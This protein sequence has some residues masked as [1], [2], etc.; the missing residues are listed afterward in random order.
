[1]G[2]SEDFRSGAGSRRGFK[3]ALL[4]GA[5]AWVGFLGF[6]SNAYAVDASKSDTA[7][8]SAGTAGAATG[9]AAAT[10]N[11]TGTDASQSAGGGSG[12]QLTDQSS[13]VTNSG[14]ANANTGGN[15]A[16]GN[17][18]ENEA[19]NDQDATNGGNADVQNNSGDTSN[20]S[21]GSANITT[22]NA[23]SVGNSSWTTINQGDPGAGLAFVD[24]EAIVTNDGDAESDTGNNTAIGN[25]SD[26]DASNDQEAGDPGDSGTIL[27]NNATTSNSSDGTAGVTTGDASSTGT[28]GTTDVGQ[29]ASTGATGGGLSFVDQ[30]VSV[31]NSGDADADTGENTAIGNDSDNEVSN[32]QDA[33][34]ARGPPGDERVVLSNIGETSNWSDGTA[35]INT[36]DAEATGVSSSTSITQSSE[37]TNSDLL[38][39]D[40]DATIENDGDAEAESG[41]NL[42]IG[43]DSD[44]DATNEQEAE[45]EQ[46]GA[47]GIDIDGTTV[48]SNIADTSNWS[49]GSA[50]IDT[51]DARG[52]GVESNDAIDQ[53]A[54]GASDADGLA[55]V[56]QE[57]SIENDGDGTG[58]SGDNTAIGNDSENEAENDQDAS[59]EEN[60]GGDLELEGVVLS[61]IADTS[62][63]SNGSADITT[64]DA[65]G[66]GV[67]TTDSVTQSA[68]IAFGDDGFVE[69]DQVVDIDNDGDASGNSG[70][71]LAIGNDSDNDATNDQDVAVEENGLGDL[72]VDDVV[73]SN[74]GTTT[75]ESNGS[76]S[77][78]TGNACACNSMNNAVSQ[79]ANFANGDAGFALFTQEADVDNHGDSD[80]N[81]G[82][83]DAI[84]NDS[85]NDASNEQES[86]VEEQDA[87]DLSPDGLV[88]S[89][90]A[91]NSNQSNGSA[92]ISTGD[93]SATGTISNT[94]IDQA[95]AFANG[96]SGFATF[97]QLAEVEND[98]D[99]VANTGDNDATGNDS[100]NE[101]DNDQDTQLL[102]RGGTAKNPPI[103]SPE[104]DSAVLSNIAENTNSSNGSASI[105]TGDATAYG[106]YSTT[107]ISQD[108][109]FANGDDG[110][111][112]VTQEADV[113]NDGDAD[114]NTG[115]NEA[116]GNNS[117]NDA[118]NDQENNI[119]EQD[120]GD[121]SIDDVV[122]S[123]IAD[124][125]NES[126]GSADI[127]TGNATAYGNATNDHIWQTAD[128][129]IE[130]KGFV[131]LDQD[132]DV[133]NS[134]DAS[135]NTGDNDADGNDSDNEVDNDQDN[136]IE[137]NGLGDLDVDDAVL[138]NISD[139]SNSSNGS[140]SIDSG[141]ANALGNYSA[142]NIVLAAAT[143]SS[144]LT[145]ADQEIEI[146]NDGDADANSGDN[147]ATGNESDNDNENEQESPL[148]ENGA[149]SLDVDG[150][151]QNNSADTSNAS[152]GSAS[153]HTGDA[154]AT[155]NVSAQSAC[156]G[157]N[158]AVDCPE[159]VLPPLP[160][161]SCPCARSET[162][163]VTPPTT[164]PPPA[165]SEGE[166]LPVTGGPL[167]A[168][169]ALGLLL[170]G[171]GSVLRRRTRHAG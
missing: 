121:L 1:M 133:D 34:S 35:T 86:N 102:E 150:L 30:E 11:S 72:D 55:F 123:N 43:N 166:E 75:N 120:A 52:L 93:A 57:A 84:G 78:T 90:I 45:I 60:D 115:N 61:N 81:S 95:A 105:A 80:A 111:A 162:P 39:V 124:T 99:A 33:T 47:G 18:S 31:E 12:L 26:N 87:G 117:D 160:P 41:D 112:L 125:L 19:T 68:D 159:A 42:A 16:I 28:T 58:N 110:F 88:Q 2:K 157:L 126:D 138:S 134:G 119:E 122:L 13:T 131:T 142:T 49:D 51:G 109:A 139:T 145:L 156:S 165:G 67:I 65:H 10:G 163:V 69:V 108:A 4:F 170:I 79:D 20:S 62:N 153:T 118:S 5:V 130:D 82:G 155:G 107:G 168:Q 44:N 38:F 141:D 89:N 143:G 106:N 46:N 97:D 70:D 100:E 71:N 85:D 127:T 40:Q 96:D 3:H 17:D 25:N 94:T 92:D 98:G 146:S 9:D 56:D 22:G 149:G 91:T 50:S 140:A 104:I 37:S 59:I 23:T 74:I 154:N 132:A 148:E 32:D 8:T 136:S 137:E 53:S 114:A 48:L 167:A 103:G 169:A 101:V 66:L 21:N 158:T 161:P 164:T 116:E 14:T 36:G 144:D 151:V 113:D 129:L 24:Q 128:L 147:E 77:I 76:A 73:Q 6:G 27:N 171:L 54:T 135:A 29:W 15:T 83:N 63:T 64:G 152:D 7:N